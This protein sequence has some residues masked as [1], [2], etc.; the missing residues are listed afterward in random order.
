MRALV[1]TIVK[2]NLPINENQS[3]GFD[4]FT[5]PWLKGTAKLNKTDGLY[6]FTVELNSPEPVTVKVDYSENGMNFVGFA[7]LYDGIDTVYT[8]E[9]ILHFTHQGENGFTVFLKP[10]QHKVA[11]DLQISYTIFSNKEK[12]HTGNLKF[13]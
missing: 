1:G 6:L 5:Y 7:P 13:K 2:D 3:N 11:K 8:G 12:T 9:D 4:A 10:E